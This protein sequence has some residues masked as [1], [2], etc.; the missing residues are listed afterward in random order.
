MAND[1]WTTARRTT[2]A[3]P[4]S[5]ALDKILNLP[6]AGEKDEAGEA[7]LESR[8]AFGLLLGRRQA[9]MLDVRH[10]DGNCRAFAFAY[11][12]DVAFNPSHGIVLHFSTHTVTLEGWNLHRV[13][14]ALVRHAVAYVQ[15]NGH[16]LDAADDEPCIERIA[17]TLRA[18][19]MEEA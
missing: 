12:M 11:L 1:D 19:E 7:E 16:A 15:E 3:K 5:A 17:V 14:H 6:P 18:E 9:V 4:R 2:D 13:Y 10:A 8:P